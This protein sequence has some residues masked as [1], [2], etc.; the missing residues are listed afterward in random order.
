MV[1]HRRRPG[2]RSTGMLLLLF[3][4][5]SP[6]RCRSNFSCVWGE[7]NK[8]YVLCTCHGSA[9][10]AVCT[11]TPPC[12]PSH[13]TALVFSPSNTC[14]T[15][16]LVNQGS[17]GGFAE[18]QVQLVMPG[19]T[20]P[21][22]P[23]SGDTSLHHHAFTHRTKIHSSHA[24]PL[25]SR[26]K[27][28]NKSRSAIEDACTQKHTHPQYICK[29]IYVYCV[30]VYIYIYIYIIHIHVHIHNTYTCICA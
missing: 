6:Q 20:R 9:K 2:C 24:F 5:P 4:K 8:N 7:C 23:Q 18:I 3:F 12:F 1:H 27:I 17:G 25:Y 29:Y 14:S 30:C 22:V 15:E 13:A 26:K 11:V 10:F 19:Q 16:S 21:P 28:I